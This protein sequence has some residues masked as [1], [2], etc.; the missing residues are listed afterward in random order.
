MS[1]ES[2]ADRSQKVRRH[3]RRDCGVI[4]NAIYAVHAHDPGVVDH[5]IQLWIVRDQALRDFLNT[6][7]VLD[8][9]FDELHAGVGLFN[10]F[11]HRLAAPGDNNLV[12]LRVQGLGQ[13]AAYTRSARR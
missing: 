5:Y 12:A 10:F 8:V 2:H 9:E 1:A 3:N 11:K 6:R 13:T 4:D 7:R